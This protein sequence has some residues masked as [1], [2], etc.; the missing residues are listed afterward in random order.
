MKVG[1]LIEVDFSQSKTLPAEIRL[2]TG[3][4]PEDYKFIGL[5]T[6]TEQD[7]KLVDGWC[8]NPN[9]YFVSILIKGQKNSIP[10]FESEIVGVIE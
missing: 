5:I 6:S 8:S 10:V 1:D 3:A 2:E 7:P 4:D 9:E